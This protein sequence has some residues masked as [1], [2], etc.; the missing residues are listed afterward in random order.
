MW[1]AGAPS[2]GHTQHCHR[3][4]HQGSK[5]SLQVADW[6]LQPGQQSQA[7]SKVVRSQ[8]EDSAST[9]Q[10]DFP[11]PWPQTCPLAAGGP[12]QRHKGQAQGHTLC[13]TLTGRRD[14]DPLFSSRRRQACHWG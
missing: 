10:E 5:G 3:Q 11:K 4:G 1:Q 9:N 13:W 7:L 14:E 2:A 6:T 12:I 8:L